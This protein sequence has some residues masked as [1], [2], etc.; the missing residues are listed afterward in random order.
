[1]GAITDSDPI[2][3]SVDQIAEQLLAFVGKVDHI[4][5]VVDPITSESIERLA[6]AVERIHQETGAV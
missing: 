4:Q 2:S 3:G 1:M 6:P 5:L